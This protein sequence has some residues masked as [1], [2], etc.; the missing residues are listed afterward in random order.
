M[1]SITTSPSQQT[2]ANEAFQRFLRRGQRAALLAK[3]SGDLPYLE[4][5]NNFAFRLQ[6]GRKHLGVQSIPVAAIT[7]SVGRRRE[8]DRQFRPLKKNLRDRWSR[9]YLNLKDGEL[10]PISVYKIGGEYFVVDGHDRVAAAKSFG[11]KS[12]Q[13]NVWEYSCRTEQAESCQPDD[14]CMCN[15]VDMTTAIHA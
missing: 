14:R 4:D 5:F 10:P 11:M 15:K 9:V 7:G 1:F 13:A 8:F 6:G 3:L 2:A 12:I